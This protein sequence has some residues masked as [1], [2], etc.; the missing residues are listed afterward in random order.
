MIH[1]KGS[2]L[3]FHV[4]VHVSA[5]IVAWWPVNKGCR[6]VVVPVAR[7][8]RTVVGIHRTRRLVILSLAYIALAVRA[9]HTH[10]TFNNSD[11]ELAD[12]SPYVLVSSKAHRT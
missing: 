3:F 11:R 10:S 5:V 1:V 6:S 2:F 4:L 7:I 12:G 8:H 9:H